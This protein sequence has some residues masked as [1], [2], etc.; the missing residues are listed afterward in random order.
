MRRTVAVHVTPGEPQPEGTCPRCSGITYV[1]PLAAILDTGV[2]LVGSV[3]ACPECDSAQ[4][5]VQNFRDQQ[6]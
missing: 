5:I 4:D 3:T 6:G 2:S 1:W